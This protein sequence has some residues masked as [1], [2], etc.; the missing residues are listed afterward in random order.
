MR[1]QEWYGS[2]L[3]EYTGK[4]VRTQGDERQIVPAKE[5]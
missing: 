4:L 2:G 3:P 5:A 1:Q